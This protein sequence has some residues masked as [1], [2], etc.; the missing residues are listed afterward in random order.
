[1]VDIKDYNQNNNELQL[2][3]TLIDFGFAV[4]YRDS[5]QA[6]KHI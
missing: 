3:I 2:E 4:K 5:S 6:N 1:M